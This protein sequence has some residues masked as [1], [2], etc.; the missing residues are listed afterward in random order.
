MFRAAQIRSHLGRVAWL[1]GFLGA[2][3]A[4]GGTGSSGRTRREA[5]ASGLV[6]AGPGGLVCLLDKAVAEAVLGTFLE[7]V[8]SELGESPDH[9]VLVPTPERPVPLSSKLGVATMAQ[10]SVDAASLAAAVLSAER[11]QGS[12]PDSGTVAAI[13]TSPERIAAS[14]SSDQLFTIDGEAPA[15]W[16]ELSGFWRTSD[17][18]IRTHANY[19]HHRERLLRALGLGDDATPEQFGAALGKR[20]GETAERLIAD[21][22]G[23]AAVMRPES[24]GIADRLSGE[25]VLAVRDLGEAPAR[26]WSTPSSAALP[27]EGVRVLDLTRVIAGPVATRNLALLGADVLRIDSP[28]LPEL[29]WQHLDTGQG[30]RS[31]RVN[32]WT[33]EGQTLLHELLSTADVVVLGYRPG[34]MDALRLVPEQLAESHPGLIVAR[35]TAWGTLPAG[36]GRRGFD[37]IV[38]SASGIA[39][40]ESPD[41][42][43]PGALPVQALD[44]ST[45]YLLAA[46]I[47]SLLGRQ[48]R[49]GGSWLVET[50]LLRLAGEL[51]RLPAVPGADPIDLLP[52]TV[53][54]PTKAGLLRYPVPA[55]SFQGSPDDYLAPPRPLGVDAARWLPRR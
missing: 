29:E 45:G 44:H 18:W 13:T 19:P 33:P 32:L 38:Q 46:G 25:P 28:L 4:P 30:K 26:E 20:T 24:D 54:H 16:A 22:E 8:W 5:R 50:S 9:F 43:T 6:H 49:S 14:Y 2:T 51:L 40:R 10:Q 37:S 35:L 34:A 3:P 41:G 12:R 17:G 55:L 27:L 21:A 42:E 53:A 48:R 31:T 11:E 52:Y 39:L 47:I 36:N 23:V 15:I 1:P 7:R